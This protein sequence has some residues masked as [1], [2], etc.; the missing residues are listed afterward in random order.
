MGVR[1]SCFKCPSQAWV[2]VSHSLI[3]IQLHGL[4][5]AG[6]SPHA[7]P[8]LTFRS[9]SRTHFSTLWLVQTTASVFCVSH[10]ARRSWRALWG[11]KGMVAG[12]RGT[13]GS[14]L[15][16]ESRLPLGTSMCLSKED[17]TQLL[18][19]VPLELSLRSGKQGEAASGGAENRRV[20]WKRPTV[21]PCS[22]SP[23]SVAS[24]SPAHLAES[25]F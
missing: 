17:H 13:S 11:D 8:P 16:C 15:E 20:G 9:I 4:T 12:T 2:L 18:G 3:C 5:L 23:M 10:R 1:G 25:R 22:V 19:P 21:L 7:P 24:R 14:H 6:E